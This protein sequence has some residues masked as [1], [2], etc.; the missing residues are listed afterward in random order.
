MY[1]LDFGLR[2]SEFGFE[3]NSSFWYCY[4]GQNY[5]QPKNSI[6]LILVYLFHFHFISFQSA[7]RL[8]PSAIRLPPSA[9]SLIRLP[10]SLHIFHILLREKTFL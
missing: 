2:I 7:F 8:P 4:G 5:L 10:E 9:F 6:P 1:S 3:I